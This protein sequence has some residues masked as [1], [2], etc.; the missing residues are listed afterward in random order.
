MVNF[1]LLL[2]L[3]DALVEEGF[4]VDVASAIIAKSSLIAL[5]LMG[6]CTYLYSR[7]STKWS[8]TL[9]SGIMT[10]GLLTVLLRGTSIPALSG[11][12]VSTTLLIIGS[13]G[14]ISMLLPYTAE[15]YPLRIRGRA[16][17]WIAGCSKLGG[18]GA[19]GLAIFTGIPPL[20][21]ASLVIA[22]PASAAIAL[23]AR[24]G[25]ETRDRDLRTL[26]A[27]GLDTR[28]GSTRIP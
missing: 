2:W 6:L 7:W 11:P 15:C 26:E 13:T 1:G 3:P 14:A 28:I 8:L 17:G 4:S 20:G 25:G 9:M 22:L 5:P 23:I 18:L 24:F 21:I 10:L 27:A 19:Q 12:V 16:S